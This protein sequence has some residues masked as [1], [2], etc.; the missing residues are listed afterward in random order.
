MLERIVVIDHAL[1]AKL[2]QPRCLAVV[3]QSAL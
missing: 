3:L 2:A 1:V